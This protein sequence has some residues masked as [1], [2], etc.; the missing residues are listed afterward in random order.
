MCVYVSG[1]LCVCVCL[2]ISSRLQGCRLTQESCASLAS[3]L[4]SDTSSLKMLSLSSN[5][6]LD[7]GVELLSAALG[8]P[9]CELEKLK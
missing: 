4:L 2:C 5:N 7:S 6:L 9:N 3:A 8:H 1:G